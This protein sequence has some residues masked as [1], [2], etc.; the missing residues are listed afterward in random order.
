MPAKKVSSKK[1]KKSSEIITPSF[2]TIG[3]L[4]LYNEWSPDYFYFNSLV[5]YAS[6]NKNESTQNTGWD[7]KAAKKKAK[8]ILDEA[9]AHK[10]FNNLSDDDASKLM[11]SRFNDILKFLDTAY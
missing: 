8:E 4:A 5:S 10:N 7:S 2:S 3:N 1:S 6:Y 9:K 11:T